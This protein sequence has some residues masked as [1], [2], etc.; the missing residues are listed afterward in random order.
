MNDR[1]DYRGE[2][3]RARV[4]GDRKGARQEGSVLR[5]WRSGESEGSSHCTV[6]V[7]NRAQSTE[8]AHGQPVYTRGTMTSRKIRTRRNVA[9]GWKSH[10]TSRSRGNRYGSRIAS[11]DTLADDFPS[12]IR[13]ITRGVRFFIYLEI[14]DDRPSDCSKNPIRLESN[15][16]L[17]RAILFG[18]RV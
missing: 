18:F 6:N 10:D 16:L 9:R 7:E 2:S 8:I 15:V 5:T 14:S 13:G 4:K 12:S 17:I 11:G 3:K 1:K